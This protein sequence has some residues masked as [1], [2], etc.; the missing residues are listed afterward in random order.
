[1]KPAVLIFAVVA[2][3]LVIAWSGGWLGVFTDTK[4][5]R[6]TIA[7]AGFWGAAALHRLG[8]RHVRGLHGLAPREWEAAVNGPRHS[9]FVFLCGRAARQRDHLRH[10][11]QAGTEVGPGPRAR[12]DPALGR[13][14]A[15]ASL[16]DHHRP[17]HSA[18][19]EPAGRRVRGGGAGPDTDLSARERRR[20]VA[21]DRVSNPA[22]C[23]RIPVLPVALTCGGMDTRRR[24]GAGRR[25][26]VRQ[27]P[28]A[29]RPEVAPLFRPGEAPEH[30][31]FDDKCTRN[32][33]SFGKHTFYG[34]NQS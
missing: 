33:C 31:S 14:P 9:P 4:A 17:T 30:L 23:G 13:A 6:A 22:R 24:R 8:I 12:F 26:L 2:V 25:L 28:R 7:Q 32:E 16:L 29:P 27:T 10:R 11:S 20:A 34:G 21:H 15:R 19:G 3:L 5:I 18:L 1:M